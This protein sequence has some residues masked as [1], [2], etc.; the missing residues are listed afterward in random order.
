MYVFINFIRALATCLITNSHFFPIYTFDALAKG[1]AFGN[2]LFFL[3]T[4]FCLYN[5]SQKFSKWY[6]KR[7]VR[8]Y[9]PVIIIA[10]FNMYMGGSVF[11]T[12]FFSFAFPA[13][14]WFVCALIILYPAYYLVVNHSFRNRKYICTAVLAVM[15]TVIYFF[16][17]KSFYN[18]ESAGIYGIRFSYIFSF[19]LMLVGGYTRKN[20]D[21][22]KQKVIQKRFLLFVAFFVSAVLYFAFLLTM[23]RFTVLYKIQFLE[24]ILCIS[25]T[26][27]LFWLFLSFE[28]FFAKYKDHLLTRVISFIGNCTL[29]IYLVQFPLI[30][31]IS[32]WRVH[33]LIKFVAAV[34]SIIICAVVLKRV[35][36]FVIKSVANFK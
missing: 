2:S 26:V 1:G 3:A 14:Y 23:Y 8:L 5:C 20:F 25:T 33:S 17:D 29:E 9:V 32:D 7:L 21:I 22:I 34:S 19:F 15:Y 27:T 35:S 10:F 13:N 24:T 31:L 30:R 4:G 16:I 18:V 36:N 28:D 11:E 12:L 6:P